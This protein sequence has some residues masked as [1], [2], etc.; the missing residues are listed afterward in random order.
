[1]EDLRGEFEGNGGVL[2]DPKKNNGDVHR[3]P[4]LGKLK[5]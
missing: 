2:Y 5:S 3:R 1:M 4:F